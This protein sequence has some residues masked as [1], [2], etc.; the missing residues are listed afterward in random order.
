[1]MCETSNSAIKRAKKREIPCFNGEITNKFFDKYL[2]SFDVIIALELIEHLYDPMTFLHRVYQL[3]N[4]G[5][6]YI[7][8]TGN[9][10]ETRLLGRRWG[11]LNIPEGHLYFFTPRTI[12]LYLR[13]VGFKRYL[14]PYKFY[15]KYNVAVRFLSKFGFLNVNKDVQ[16]R[17]FVEK[18]IY[19]YLFKAIESILGRT[20]LP[21]AI[22]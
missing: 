8:T 12:K 20:R 14:S 9:F 5:G 3:L 7:Y 11:Y 22:K 6:V 13:K 1:M 2:G 4:P 19:C 10:Q 16:P 15:Y 18:I 21:F 17:S